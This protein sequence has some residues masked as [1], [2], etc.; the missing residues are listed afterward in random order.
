MTDTMLTLLIVSFLIGV[1][2]ASVLVL[3]FRSRKV[4]KGADGGRAPERELI[5]EDLDEAPLEGIEEGRLR[6]RPGKGLP[7]PISANSGLDAPSINFGIPGDDSRAAAEGS[8]GAA[9]SGEAEAAG[10]MPYGPNGPESIMS[11][12]DPRESKPAESESSSFEM[13]RFIPPRIVA[14]R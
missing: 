1:A 4:L 9:A 12:Q 14:G 6:S 5:N 3:A 13:M 10:S 7:K 8:T 11:A 2:I